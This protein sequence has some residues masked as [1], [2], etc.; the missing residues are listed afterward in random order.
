MQMQPELDNVPLCE[1]QM[2]KCQVSSL[3]IIHRRKFSE[4]IHRWKSNI[5]P[6]RKKINPQKY[7]LQKDIYSWK[8]FTP[9]KYLILKIF[10][11]VKYS[12][13]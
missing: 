1:T 4:N 5:H 3:R 9:E 2:E 10:T 7:S 8:I 12:P 13:L 6:L 11:P